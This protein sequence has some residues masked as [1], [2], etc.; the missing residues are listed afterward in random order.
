MEKSR[1][2]G[3]P[4]YF[5]AYMHI[6]SPSSSWG[7]DRLRIDGAEVARR[8]HS[9]AQE[10]VVK[11]ILNNYYALIEKSDIADFGG[12]ARKLQ[13]ACAKRPG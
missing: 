5:N 6:Y 12:R 3:Q 13:R 9:A 7:C 11:R 2:N 4:I 1:I 10:R 8:A